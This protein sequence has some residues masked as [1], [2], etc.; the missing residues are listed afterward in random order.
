MVAAE[1]VIVGCII[2]IVAHQGPVVSVVLDFQSTPLPLPFIRCHLPPSEV[3]SP[4]PLSYITVHPLD[5]VL[6][7][8]CEAENAGPRGEPEDRWRDLSESAKC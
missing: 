8:S 5:L 3:K 2:I 7:Q 1:V 6:L 4:R